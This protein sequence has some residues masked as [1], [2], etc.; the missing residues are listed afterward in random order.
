LSYVRFAFFRID[1]KEIDG[2]VPI[3]TVDENGNYNAAIQYVLEDT[4]TTVADE[5][6]TTVHCLLTIPGTD[7]EKTIE[8]SY[9]C[10]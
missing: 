9:K 7:Y 4:D 2:L 5:D 1:K 10:T 3:P 6:E 8:E